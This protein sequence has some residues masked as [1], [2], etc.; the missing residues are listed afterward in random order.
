LLDAVVLAR[1]LFD[2]T[3][4]DLASPQPPGN[5]PSRDA[6]TDAATDVA[7]A[8]AAAAFSSNSAREGST[9]SGAAR[10][11]CPVPVALVAYATEMR[12]RAALKMAT[13]RAN[14]ALLHSLAAL[15]PAHGSMTR[16]A[17]AAQAL[18]LTSEK[19]AS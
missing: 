7:A 6:T 16:A 19:P 18:A 9:F 10:S 8:P 4:G 2:S 13:S 11:R 3:L 5:G 1:A 14:S 17:A 12:G 15:T